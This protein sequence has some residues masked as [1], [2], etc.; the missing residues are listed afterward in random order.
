MLYDRIN[1][2]MDR[3]IERGLFEEAKQFYDVRQLNALRTVGYQEI[4]GFIEGTYDKEEAI[5]LLKR[6][7][8]RYAKRQ[9]TWFKKNKTIDWFSVDDPING[10]EEVFKYLKKRLT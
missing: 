9:M 5:R 4:Y 6:N 2:R 3:M 7:S 8:R 10:F 1:T